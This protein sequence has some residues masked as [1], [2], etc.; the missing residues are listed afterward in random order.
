MPPALTCNQR[1]I[2][3]PSLRPGHAHLS[4]GDVPV[5]QRLATTTPQGTPSRQHAERARH[6]GVFSYHTR[7][8]I[9][10]YPA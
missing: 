8:L 10:L 7:C 3:S 9:V 4:G 5:T 2:C 1:T 6:D